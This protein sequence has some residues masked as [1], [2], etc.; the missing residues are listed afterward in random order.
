MYV[1]D[2]NGE[3]IWPGREFTN[4]A[5]ERFRLDKV[6]RVN[7]QVTRE[8]GLNYDMPRQNFAIGCTLVEGTT[9]SAPSWGAKNKAA[10]EAFVEKVQAEVGVIKPGMIVTYDRQPGL[11][12]VL[13]MQPK[14]GR[15]D[16]V[17]LG[18]SQKGHDWD[19][20]TPLSHLHPVDAINNMQSA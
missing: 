12:V 11:W 19:W 18:G 17:A 2:K 6:N 1:R 8:D 13:K 15:A 16:I 4:R 20:R 10:R 3:N 5:G 14:T 9:I 7:C